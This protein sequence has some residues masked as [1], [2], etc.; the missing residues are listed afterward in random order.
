MNV[1]RRIFTVL[2]LLL[3]AL[4]PRAAQALESGG[5]SEAALSGEL[6][7]SVE[8]YLEE[9]GEQVPDL[10]GQVTDTLSQLKQQLIESVKAPVR[11]LIGVLAVALVATVAEQ[12]VFPST[13]GAYRYMLGIFTSVSILGV[14]LATVGSYLSQA[15]RAMQSAGDFFSGYLPTL[16]GVMVSQGRP[17]AAASLTA[18]SAAAVTGLF[19]LSSSV[20]P[21]LNA[22][23]LCLAA[24]SAVA[25]Q[26]TA[27]ALSAVKK[28][29]QWL[30]G[31][32][33]A[34][35]ITV[36]RMQLGIAAAADS[37]ALKTGRFLVGEAVPIVGSTV[38]GAVGTVVSAAGLT[39]GWVGTAGVCALLALFLPPIVFGIALSACL[40]IASFAADAL[41][42][43]SPGVLC[44][45]IRAAVDV[46]TAFLVAFFVV[47]VLSLCQ[48]VS[49]GGAV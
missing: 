23:M 37:A 10:M 14:A 11:L 48:A 13:S 15:E 36:L 22:A 47:I 45:A 21:A 46:N 9:D 44:G 28:T 25:Q 3:A 29:L 30:V 12:L 24:A 39:G 43:G 35:A 40:K 19:A 17:T 26:F 31:T 4:Q 32:A 27:K 38:S 2:F 6:P 7:E 8:R 18:F 34:V 49:M 41:G 42:G 16:A 1:K 33:A 20:M 5:W